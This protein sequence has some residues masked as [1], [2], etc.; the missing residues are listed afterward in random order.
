MLHFQQIRVICG[1][2][3]IEILRYYGNIRNEICLLPLPEFHVVNSHRKSHVH[4]ISVRI[5]YLTKLLYVFRLNLAFRVN[6]LK[7]E[8]QL[9]FLLAQYKSYFTRTPKQI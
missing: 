9:W 5:F 7:R 1:F 3:T 4:I 2:S 6:T 8:I